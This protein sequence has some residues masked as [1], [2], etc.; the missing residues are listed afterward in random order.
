MSKFRKKINIWCTL[1]PSS[2][3]ERV[4]KRLTETG[5]SMFRINLSHTRPDDIEGVVETIRKYTSVPICLDTEG[6]QVR[7]GLIKGKGVLL[8]ENNT[9]AISKKDIVGHAESFTIRPA[10]VL[11]EL[12]V[13]DLISVDFDSVLLGIACIEKDFLRAKVITGGWIGSNKAVTID[14]S[15]PMPI[16]SKKDKLGIKVL[17]KCGLKYLSLSFVHKMQDVELA[18][19]L[20]GKN[21]SIVSKIETNDALLNLNE[22]ISASDGILIDRGDL[23]RE[24]PINKI[25]LLQKSI[26]KMANKGKKPVF[27][28]TNLLESMVKTKKPLRSEVNDVMNTLLDGADGLVLAAETAIGDYPVE[29]AN[30]IKRMI[31]YYQIAEQGYSFEELLKKDS[32]LLIEPH[33]GELINRYNQ[34]VDLKV[35]KSLPK[36]IVDERVIMDAEQIGIGTYS[37]LTGFMNKDDLF[38]VL[39]NYHLMSG[40]PWTLPIVLQVSKSDRRR[41]KKNHEIAL[42]YEKDNKIYAVLT[43]TDVFSVDLKKAAKKWFGTTDL[44]HPG[45]KHLFDKGEYFIGGEITLVRRKASEHKEFEFTPQQTRLIFEHKE[46]SKVAGF[47]TRNAIHRAHEYLQMSA[48]EK[49]GLDGLFLHPVVGPKKSQDFRPQIILESYQVMLDNF[50][51]KGKVVLGAFSAY[52]HYAGPREAVFTALCRKNFGCSHFIIGRDHTGVKDY[53]KADATIKLLEKIGDIG[54]TPIFFNTIHYCKKCRKYVEKCVHGDKNYL[55]ISGTQARKMLLE[56][57]Q[58]PQWFLRSKISKMIMEKIE[59]GIEVFVK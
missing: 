14:K 51:P 4:I 21:V 57:K 45:V 22:I 42:V 43:V 52:S 17:K 46:W 49:Y 38:S 1:G 53:Y 59:K 36:L 12:E 7:T 20:V 27:V 48:L 2:L 9:V 50:Y 29:C 18:R 55:H 26:I 40:V 8:K 41:F 6:P 11:E 33:G 31:K 25:P 39:D 15:I 35:I 5:V 44:E 47:H 56:K 58:P 28:A 23:S 34:N 54:I 16:L 10:N 13:G 3:N 30:M 37:P 24:E 19:K 32:F